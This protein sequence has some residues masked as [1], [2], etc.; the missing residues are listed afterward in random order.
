MISP[1]FILIGLQSERNDV[2]FIILHSNPKT[3]KEY[4]ANRGGTK[5]QRKADVRAVEVTARILFFRSVVKLDGLAEK[6]EVF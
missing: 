6:V 1:F 5:R 4:E 3:A 2:I